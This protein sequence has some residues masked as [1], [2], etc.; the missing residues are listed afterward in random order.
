MVVEDSRSEDGYCESRQSE[1][2]IVVVSRE[3]QR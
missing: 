1:V 2:K 3:R